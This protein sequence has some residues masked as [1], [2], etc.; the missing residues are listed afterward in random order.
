MPIGRLIRRRLTRSAIALS[1][2]ESSASPSGCLPLC[3]IAILQ[4]GSAWLQPFGGRRLLLNIQPDSASSSKLIVQLNRNPYTA[5]T[6]IIVG[7]LAYL[8]LYPFVFRV[9]PDDSGAVRK[10]FES[11]AEP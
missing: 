4:S 8:E 11:W 7:G 1:C 10:L 3:R 2:G 5:L 6:L 9:P